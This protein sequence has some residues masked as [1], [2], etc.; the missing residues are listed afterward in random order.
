MTWSGVH[1]WRNKDWVPGSPNKD[2][3]CSQRAGFKAFGRQSFFKENL[4]Y[5]LVN[6]GCWPFYEKPVIVGCFSQEEKNQYSGA[7]IA[8]KSTYE[9][10]H[11]SCHNYILFCLGKWPFTEFS[12]LKKVSLLKALETGLRLWCCLYNY[13]YN[14]SRWIFKKKNSAW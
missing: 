1:P 6:S 9:K 2:I 3:R 10:N 11:L 4:I 7:L 5:G 12:H 8:D 13:K 14:K